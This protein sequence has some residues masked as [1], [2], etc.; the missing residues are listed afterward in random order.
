MRWGKVKDRGSFLSVQVFFAI[1]S[2]RCSR[3]LEGR[4]VTLVEDTSLG[5]GEENNTDRQSATRSFLS[6][7]SLPQLNS[8]EINGKVTSFFLLLTIYEFTTYIQWSTVDM[9]L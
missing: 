5:C 1:S 8:Y 3:P 7:S 4:A 9:S 2:L 6:L